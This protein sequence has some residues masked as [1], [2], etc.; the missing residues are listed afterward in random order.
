MRGRDHVR[1][2]MRDACEK[3]LVERT[4]EDIERVNGDDFAVSVGIGLGW[5][6]RGTVE[7]DHRRSWIDALMERGDR[8]RR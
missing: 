1:V 8:W 2:A 3:F 6:L 7:E 5:L 4:W